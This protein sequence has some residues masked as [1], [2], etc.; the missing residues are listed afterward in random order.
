[1]RGKH[2]VR[3]GFDARQH[4]RTGGG[5]GN[6]SGVFSF[7]NLYTRR[8]DDTFT[9]AG[10]LGLSWA[11]FMMG[12]PDGI[13]IATNDTFATHTPYY[14][15]YAQ[16]SWRLTPR[17]TLN[18]GLRLEYENGA[19]ERYNRVIGSFDPA[20]KLPITEAAQTAY[21]QS[22][23]PELPAAAFSVLGGSLYPGVGGA[24]RRLWKDALLWL[25]RAAAAYQLNARSVLRAGYGLFYDTL[26]VLN[27]GPDQTGFSR[28]TMTVVTTD[29]GLNWR[30]GDP[31][32]GISPLA[33]PFHVRADGT[34]FD[35][36][37][38]DGLGLM[39]RAGRGWS[40]LDFNREH[41]R[42]HRWR[43]SFQRQFGVHTVIDVAYAGSRSDRVRIARAMSPL[44]EPFWASGLVRNDTIA[45]NLNANVPNPF[46]I[47]HFASLQSSHPLVYQDL[48]TQGFFT[49]T[50]I[51]KSSLLR[52]FPHMNGLT[53]SAA[54]LGEVKTHELQITV[55]RRFSRGL[56]FN[57]GYTHMYNRTADY[58]H[59]EFDSQ[60]SWRD[61]N[62]SRPHRIVGT[63]VYELPFGKG[64]TWA[65]QGL[66]N[67]LLGGLQLSATYEWQPGPLLDFGNLF[68]YGNL[69]DIRKGTRTLER[70]F[71]TDGFE[72]VAAR[73]P[74]AF[75]RRV[76]P[77]R[78]DGLRADMTNQWNTSLQRE[79]KIKERVGLQ[80][81]FDAINLQNR[82]QMNPPERNPLSTNFGRITTQSAA[83]NRLLQIHGRLQW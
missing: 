50:T 70:W 40:F 44:P 34:R 11:A 60:P 51:R 78:I 7:S 32:N 65:R 52:P 28:A 57:F 79:F 4:F 53:N 25:P 75:H 48:A 61:S 33:D 46:N 23:I 63:T 56:S 17:L 67:Y 39:A 58:F 29:F 8:N 6:S 47:R 72:R 9:P 54:S 82:S 69:E 2:S 14:A 21:A 10:D 5:G 30:A 36:P 3:G 62:T 77:T 35:V 20:A 66:M 42:Q 41:A 18:L 31:R 45:N 24:S 80:V 73:G 13:S 22:P 76:F 74:A 15:G 37:V 83:L 26:N 64:R 19:T 49:S 55:E 68:Y 38:R 71:N 59:D 27:E 1:M 16:E 81:R 43:V 12:L